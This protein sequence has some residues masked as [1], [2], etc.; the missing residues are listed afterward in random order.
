MVM[1]ELMAKTGAMI[2]KTV[3]VAP[4]SGMTKIETRAMNARIENKYLKKVEGGNSC[5][6]AAF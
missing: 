5:H 4:K 1:I 3:L 2:T 6:T